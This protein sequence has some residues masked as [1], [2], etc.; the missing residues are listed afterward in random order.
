L[1]NPEVTPALKQ[2]I[3]EGVLQ[4]AG[5][6]SVEQLAKQENELLVGLLRLRA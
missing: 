4:E 2:T 6:R 5:S 3:T 1:G